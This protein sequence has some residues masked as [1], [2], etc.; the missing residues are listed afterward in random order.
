MENDEKLVADVPHILVKECLGLATQEAA[1][2]LDLARM[3]VV[4]LPGWVGARRLRVVLTRLE[5]ALDERQ[6]VESWTEVVALERSPYNPNRTV[7]YESQRHQVLRLQPLV[8]GLQLA[9]LPLAL[10]HV[11]DQD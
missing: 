10:P 6:H 4:G 5:L 7:V 1:D 8:G 2:A 3:V 11:L 9:P